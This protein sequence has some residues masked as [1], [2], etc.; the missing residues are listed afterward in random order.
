M[1]KPSRKLLIANIISSGPPNI[2]FGYWE[3]RLELRQI[4]AFV[5]FVNTKAASYWNST[6]SQIMCIC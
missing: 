2:G 3:E 4:G 1:Q 6:S 5:L